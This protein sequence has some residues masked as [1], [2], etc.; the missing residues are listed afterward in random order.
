[1]LNNKYNL[2][3]ED[4]YDNI[5]KKID[6][7]SNTLYN[8]TTYETILE[9][10]TNI[11]NNVASNSINNA[12]KEHYY[13]KLLSILLYDLDSKKFCKRWL[14]NYYETCLLNA[15]VL[16]IDVHPHNKFE[17]C[18]D[19]CAETSSMTLHNIFSFSK[20]LSKPIIKKVT[21]YDS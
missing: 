21:D 12:T 18:K 20:G 3:I 7:E 15:K 19:R 11:H 2:N 8:Y 4:T 1:L 13:S 6:D 16:D 10:F 14:F 9:Y 5:K 17:N